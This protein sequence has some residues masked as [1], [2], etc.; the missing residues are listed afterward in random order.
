MAIA[1]YNNTNKPANCVHFMKDQLMAITRDIEVQNQ[2]ILLKNQEFSNFIADD[3]RQLEHSIADM[4]TN[5]EITKNECENISVAMKKMQ[6][7]CG[8][9][10]SSF[11]SMEKT[12]DKLEKLNLDIEDV[13]K[14]TNLIAMNATVEAARSGDAGKGFAVI[15]DEIRRLSDDNQ[16]MSKVSDTNRNEIVK[17]VNTLLEETLSLSEE[18]TEMSEKINA[19]LSSASNVTK[20]AGHVQNIADGVRTRLHELNS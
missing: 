6:E 4:I 14:Q 8:L 12:L 20:E 16:E 5:S 9:L 19:L 17:S 10:E 3:F 18:I 11:A 15:A 1:I 7:F 13:S 2:Q